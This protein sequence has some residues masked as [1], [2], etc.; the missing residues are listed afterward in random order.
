MRTSKCTSEC[1]ELVRCIEYLIFVWPLLS[2]IISAS[3][4]S[5]SSRGNW[6]R[7]SFPYR[8]ICSFSTYSLISK[9]SKVVMATNY[10]K[11]SFLSWCFLFCPF[12]HLTRG[13]TEMA[14]LNYEAVE[15]GNKTVFVNPTLHSLVTTFDT[16][17]NFVM[18]VN[19]PEQRTEIR[20]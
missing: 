20:F 16:F 4:N 10:S 17:W 1:W 18:C 14:M 7:L 19:T 12:F 5:G 13:S 3:S 6:G 2:R 11:R 8:C 15:F 9:L